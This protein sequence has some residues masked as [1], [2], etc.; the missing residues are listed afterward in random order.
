VLVAV[1]G[2]VAVLAA[3]VLVVRLTHDGEALPGTE[4]AGVEAGG[5]TADQL[6]E[7][8]EQTAGPQREIV[9]LAAIGDR[10]AGAGAGRAQAGLPRLSV[11][12]AEAGYSVDLGAS[13]QKALDAGRDGF[14]GGAFSTVK[15]LVATR[16]VQLDAAVDAD[17][18]DR[19]V[20]SLARRVDRPPF[21]GRLEISDDG[22]QVEAEP[23][24]A[25]RRL[26]RAVLRAR[27]RAALL[28]RASGPV[29]APVAERAVVSRQQVDAVAADAERFL[30]QPLVLTGD[31][32]PLTVEPARVAPVLALEPRA[33]G[34]RVR[35][36][37]D[38]EQLDALVAQIARERDRPARDATVE[39]PARAEVVDGKEDVTWSPQPAGVTVTPAKAGR[40]V[41][42]PVLA[43]AIERAV[44]DGAH[45]ARLPVKRVEPQVTTRTARAMTN[46]IGTF[47]TYYEAGQPRV[48]NIQKIAAAVDGAVIP[49]GGS[50]SLN[51]VAGERTR[52]KGYVPAPF[53]ADGRLVPSVGGGVSQFATTIY[54]AAYFAGLQLDTSQPHSA[55]I[56][57][58]PAGREATLNYP[59]IDLA[60][61][62][63]TDAPVLVRT[64]TDDAG[65]TV[66]LYG[67]NGDRTV[68]AETGG[69][70]P[71]GAGFS[72][73]VTRVIRRPGGETTRTPR[74]TTYTPLDE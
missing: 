55:Y 41:D 13:V 49:P 60:W 67:D 12:A 3:V 57:R 59:D 25:G 9:V 17:Q 22:R 73:E 69:R 64:Y 30:A 63:D 21:P 56:E 42:Q 2:V 4:I 48:T 15:G 1:A 11:R 65:V 5:L 58:Y 37:V 33:G 10:G 72:I 34:R 68:T 74:T 45:A 53:I 36:G 14:L 29:R 52:E 19:A 38:R 8:L 18:L 35:L 20:N 54:N 43:A 27:L 46:L 26:D 61:T 31:G 6:R 44:R 40:T 32:E 23:P 47:T 7:R 24:R 71:S 39:A 28:G 62:N 51:G 66:S 50:F 70:T 16:E